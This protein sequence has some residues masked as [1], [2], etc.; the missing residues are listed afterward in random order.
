MS[1]IDETRF[2]ERIKFFNG[3]RL[4]ASDLQGLEEFNREM[5]WLHNESLHQPGVGNG[6]A[7]TGEKGDREV[8][9]GPGYAIDSQGREIV[10]T[11]PETQP[12]PPVAGNNGQSVFY[13]L[14]VSYPADSD[15]VEAETRQGVCSPAGAIRLQEAPV[16]CWVELEGDDLVPKKPQLK[17]DIQ[18]GLKV[19]LARVEIF[20]CQ[21]NSRVSTAQRQS[22]RP[23]QTPYIGAGSKDV[24]VDLVVVTGPAG[25]L[26]TDA[27]TITETVDT[28]SAEFLSTPEYTANITGPRSLTLQTT[29]ADVGLLMLDQFHITSSSRTQIEIFDLVAVV[30][31]DGG[32]L[33]KVDAI[34]TG[35]SV[36][37]ARSVALQKQIAAQ[38]RIVWMGVEA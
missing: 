11:Q 7:V 22:A 27:F 1:I 34:I 25:S 36:P 13:D 29:G 9:I 17:L 35:S 33:T 28:S 8:T 38:W 6:Y 5:R 18:N 4:L 16:F 30:F 14:V 10:L 31:L 37:V 21:L 26:S 3:Q 32:T 19:R 2:V 15:L 12:V 24:D 20:N 23:A